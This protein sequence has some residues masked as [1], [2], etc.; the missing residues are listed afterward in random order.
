MNLFSGREICIW[1]K[2]KMQ[3]RNLFISSVVVSARSLSKAS[4]ASQGISS[5]CAG[6]TAVSIAYMGDTAIQSVLFPI[7]IISQMINDVINKDIVQTT[8]VDWR[9]D[10]L[11]LFNTERDNSILNFSPVLLIVLE[12]GLLLDPSHPNVE[13]P[14][15][16]YKWFLIMHPIHMTLGLLQRS[17]VKQPLPFL[18]QIR[19]RFGL[20]SYCLIPPSCCFRPICNPLNARS[21]HAW[22]EVWFDDLTVD[23]CL[24]PPF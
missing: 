3:P 8:R 9:F 22:E 13:L 18:C 11:F 7:T 10:N 20:L 24:R 6:Q 15:L 1:W 17:V 2:S 4:I 19:H 14:L 16:N 23:W 5:S 21:K 12:S